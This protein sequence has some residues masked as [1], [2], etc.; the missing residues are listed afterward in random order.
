[1]FETDLSKIFQQLVITLLGYNAC[2]FAYGQTGSGKSYTMMGS[3]TDPGIIPRLCSNLFLETEKQ[4]G[5][6]TEIR[7]EV[8]YME[9]YN[10]KVFDLLDLS[11]SGKVGL[12]VREHTIFGPYVEG[13]SQLAV[14]S[15]QEHKHL[16]MY[17][18]KTILC[19]HSFIHVFIRNYSLHTFIYSC[20]H[21]KLFFAYIHLFMYSS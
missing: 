6:E 19:I 12:R 21:P 9:I 4:S 3:R 20:I 8:S 7:V 5:Q 11:I 16:F 10:E 18:F 2:L 17:S 15:A 14:V 13:L 1:M